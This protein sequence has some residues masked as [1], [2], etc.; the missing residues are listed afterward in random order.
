MLLVLVIALLHTRKYMYAI[1]KILCKLSPST[2]CDSSCLWEELRISLSESGG[3]LE[4]IAILLVGKRLLLQR[5]LPGVNVLGWVSLDGGRYF[6][7][8]HF[9]FGLL[10]HLQP[11][12]RLNQISQVD[13]WVSLGVGRGIG[14][15]AHL[16]AS[17]NK[18]FKSSV[19]F[20]KKS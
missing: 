19:R 14:G 10:G 6:L 13:V 3:W 20:L 2:Y 1:T 8:F 11:V 4:P 12:D 16:R 7:Y 17:Q 15:A 9:I 5:V 18:S